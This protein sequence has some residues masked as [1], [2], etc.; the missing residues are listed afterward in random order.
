MTIKISVFFRN[1]RFYLSSQI[2]IA[3]INND[4]LDF[5]IFSWDYP[6]CWSSI[7]LGG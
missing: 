5:D 1:I 3:T 4:I 7:M 2:K 6:S